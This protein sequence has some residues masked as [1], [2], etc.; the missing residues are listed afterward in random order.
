M[1]PLEVV[2]WEGLFGVTA[3]SLLLIPFYFIPVGKGFG[4][5]PRGVLEDAL[6]GFTQIKNTPLLAL[7]FFLSVISIAFFNFAG[8]TIT[9]D[10]SATSR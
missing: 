2:G 8:I 10:V 6:H 1:A 4:Q 5:N 7:A 3:M 9:K